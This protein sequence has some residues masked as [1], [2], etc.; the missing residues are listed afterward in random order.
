MRF[1]S[2]RRSPQ[3]RALIE[4]NAPKRTGAVFSPESDILDAALRLFAARGVGNVSLA[5]VG[6]AVELPER[7]L[8]YHFTDEAA[9]LGALL[10]RTYAVSLDACM[11]LN[12]SPHGPAARVFRAVADRV[13]M[14]GEA[15]EPLRRLFRAP[16]LR[17]FDYDV[18]CPARREFETW[19]AERIEDGIE[20]GE[21]RKV[22][23]V[24]SAALV[25][26]LADSGFNAD[27]ALTQSPLRDRAFA[28]AEFAVAALL[29][30]PTALA[31]IR[32]SV[33]R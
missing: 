19:I 16:E 28:A 2:K 11:R 21:F 8:R 29:R 32:A 17:G 6:R 12:R 9:L 33:D 5:D 13:M 4:Q 7:Y 20:N 23:T 10:N 26:E 22:D 25:R 31:R 27:L 15:D 1:S 14:L 24:S 30:D 3:R 18:N